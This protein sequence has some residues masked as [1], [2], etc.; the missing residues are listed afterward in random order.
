MRPLGEKVDEGDQVGATRSVPVEFGNEQGLIRRRPSRFGGTI[1]RQA[2]KPC[3]ERAAIAVGKFLFRPEHRDVE[4]HQPVGEGE[5]EIAVGG[6][7]G[8]NGHPATGTA[9]FGYLRST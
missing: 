4:R 8:A 1:V 9:F 5:D 7:R 2:V 6:L 3:C